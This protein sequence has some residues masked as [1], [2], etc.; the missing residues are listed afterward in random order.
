MKIS[1]KKKAV[2]TKFDWHGCGGPT[3]WFSVEDMGDNRIPIIVSE[4]EMH[5][6]CMSTNRRVEI[7]LNISTDLV[8]D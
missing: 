7:E 3:V 4:S 1:L 5:N 2:A 6:L 8:T